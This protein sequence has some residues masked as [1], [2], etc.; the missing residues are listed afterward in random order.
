MKNI[1]T[2]CFLAPVFLCYAN[3]PKE[4]SGTWIGSYTDHG[5]F[6]ATIPL[7]LKLSAQGDKFSG[8]TMDIKDSISLSNM[9]LS[10]TCTAKTIT[11][12]LEQDPNSDHKPLPSQLSFVNL[13][14]LSI[15]L[16]WQNA[17]IGGF[18]P[19]LLERKK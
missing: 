5:P 15:D 12:Y 11:F 17:M 7:E 10:G 8:Y 13:N 4:L 2:V 9:T 16:Y 14:E 6:D 1:F 19:A 3:C 18:G